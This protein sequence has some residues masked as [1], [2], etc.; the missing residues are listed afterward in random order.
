MALVGLAVAIPATVLLR[1]SGGDRR[2]ASQPAAEQARS[3][4]PSV[5]L[6]PKPETSGGLDAS[7]RVPVGW[8][9]TQEQSILKLRS[10]DRS[11][12]VAISAPAARGQV[13]PVLDSLLSE[14]KARYRGVSVA[15]GTGKEVGGLKAKGAVV[16]AR[17][18]DGTALRM[19]VAVASGKAHTYL[20]QVVTARDAPAQRLAEAQLALNALRLRG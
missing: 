12:E 19:L 16:A 20:V 7:A 1:D 5:K 4:T 18:G 14:I 13:D 2:P 8:N 10:P 3:Q 15:P 11:T 17:T 9:A 6:R